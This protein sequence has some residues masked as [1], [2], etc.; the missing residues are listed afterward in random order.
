[1]RRSLSVLLPLVFA[2][3]AVALPAHAEGSVDARLKARG[4]NY[5]VDGDGDYVVTYNYSKEGRT[6]LAFV[7]G[8]T[9]S[10]G[11]FSMREVFSPAGRVKS[12]GI[13]GAKALELLAASRRAKIGSWEIGG[14]ILYYVIKLPDGADAAQLE[15]ALQIAAE[16]AD[17]MEIELSGN[18]DAL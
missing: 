8:G 9:E 16:V 13:D 5:E 7:S 3:S 1:M 4:I 17:D 6:Q 10:I 18:K 11:G 14:D 2:A 15:A 12:D